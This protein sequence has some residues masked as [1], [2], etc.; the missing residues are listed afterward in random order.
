MKQQEEQKNREFERT[1]LDDPSEVAAP[2]LDS[3]QLQ[4]RDTEESKEEVHGDQNNSNVDEQQPGKNLTEGEYATE[5]QE[6]VMDAVC[7][8]E[9]L[10]FKQKLSNLMRQL[11]SESIFIHACNSC[12]RY[13][14]ALHLEYC[15]FCH[16]P[17]E[18]F[19]ASISPS[20]AASEMCIL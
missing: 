15:L 9:E 19:D 4:E 14:Q 7:K 3:Q 11:A 5:H 8:P 20:G 16:S 10:S 6:R 13:G 2:Q 17:N 18:F 1:L 12:H